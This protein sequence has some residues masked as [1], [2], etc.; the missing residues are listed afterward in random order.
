MEE[1]RLDIATVRFYDLLYY[2]REHAHNPGSSQAN[3][4]KQKALTKSLMRAV[5]AGA[6]DSEKELFVRELFAAML[7]VDE[8]KG[9]AGKRKA[10]ALLR[11]VALSQSVREQV[12]EG[13]VDRFHSHWSERLFWQI[14]EERLLY[15][16][17]FVKHDRGVFDRE[18]AE[19]FL[20]EIAW[21]SSEDGES[22]S[23]IKRSL[24]GALRRRRKRTFGME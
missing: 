18:A 2:F 17:F 24:I 23:E 6:W 3:T 8:L 5:V 21:A 4:S 14:N 15:E 9:A 1:S 20:T 13:L 19:S 12:D 10:D 7:A 11:A 16:D 22:R